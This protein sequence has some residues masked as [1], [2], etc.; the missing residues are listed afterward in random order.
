[1]ALLCAV[2]LLVCC[3]CTGDEKSYPDYTEQFYINDFAGVM[4]DKDAEEIVKTGAALDTASA[5]KLGAQVGA[6]VVAV[7]VKTTDGDEISEYALE[8]GN[9]WGIGNKDEN[10]GVLILLATE[11]RKIWV[12]VGDGLGGALPDSKTGRFIDTYAGE[13]LSENEFSA[14]VLNLYRALV[15]EVYA[16]YNLT[17]PGE[18]PAPQVYD[19]GIS[20]SEAVTAWIGIIVFLVVFLILLR[21]KSF[22]LW[23]PPT[24]RGGSGGFGGFGGG[25]GSFGGGGFSGGGGSFGGGG[26]GRSF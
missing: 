10:N 25:G 8:L 2:V 7:T 15:R 26:A 23:I 11:D 4:T 1:M 14:G 24:Y 13:Y 5:E 22:F 20:D 12:S 21:R 16:E 6:Q 3:G 17:L 19:D 9:K 18:L